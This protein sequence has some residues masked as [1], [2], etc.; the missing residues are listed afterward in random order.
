MLLGFASS[1]SIKPLRTPTPQ[2]ALVGSGFGVAHVGTMIAL[3]QHGRP[4][5]VVLVRPGLPSS[6]PSSLRAGRPQ[7]GEGHQ[8]DCFHHPDCELPGE[9]LASAPRRAV[10]GIPMVVIT[11]DILESML[12]S[13]H[14]TDVRPGSRAG[15]RRPEINYE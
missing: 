4:L 15:D 8:H 7:R 6:I 3:I 12:M 11:A 2:S 5:P 10:V 1:F 9:Q 14:E 13:E